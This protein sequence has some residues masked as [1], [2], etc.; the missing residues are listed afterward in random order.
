MTTVMQY[1]HGIGNVS[2][3]FTCGCE[4]EIEDIKDFGQDTHDFIIE[5]DNSL[6]NNGKEF[7][8]FPRGYADTLELFERLHG[9][10]KL[11][12]EPFSERTSIHVHV[13]VAQLT[14]NEARQ[15]VLTYALVEPLFF[16]FVGTTRSNSIYCVPLNYTFL[17]S[18]YKKDIIG[19]IASWHKYTAFNIKPMNEL[20]TVE[21]RHLY[22]TND[23]EIFTKWL[24]A[25]KEIFEWVRDTENWD[26]VKALEETG[27]VEVARKVV[28]TL[29]RDYQHAELFDLLKDTSLDVKLSVGGLK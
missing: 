28:P 26:V 3:E 22:G 11:G 20:G 1:Y 25:L 15:L 6:R 27:S 2:R 14:L 16:K 19:M 5:D 12:P 8:T 4:F 21:F 23:K 17:P 7:K 10:L 29:V 24:T 18:V 9:S 13:N